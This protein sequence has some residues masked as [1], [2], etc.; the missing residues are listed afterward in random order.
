MKRLNSIICY[1]ALAVAC[2]L[3]MGCGSKASK[4]QDMSGSAYVGTY[5]A[6]RAEFLGQE[7]SIEEVLE[8]KELILQ[9]NA[10]GTGT[11]TTG[12]DVSTGTWSEVSGGIKL[13][14]DGFNMKIDDKGDFLET[15]V[16]GVTIQL[17]K[18]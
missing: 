4:P 2:V 13:Q 14:G 17:E 16:L 10:D 8:G 5:K 7:A 12:E 18:Q 15:T 11:L 3:L 9:L 1:L 6:M